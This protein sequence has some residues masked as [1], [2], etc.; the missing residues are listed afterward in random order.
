MSSAR[1]GIPFAGVCSPHR[2]WLPMAADAEP[3]RSSPSHA[4]RP[5]LTRREW[6]IVLVLAAVQFTH[7]VDFVIIMPLG[8][9]LMTELHMS[10]DQFGN[11]IA[12]YAFAATITS[13]LASGVTDRFDR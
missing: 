2:G 6:G 3:S 11:V 4:T 10:A 5:G 7:M 8:K 9:R 12:A 13:L 1:D